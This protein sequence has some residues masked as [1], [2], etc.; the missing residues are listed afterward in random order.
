MLFVPGHN[1]KL[2]ESA[3]RSGA[4]A[5]ILDIEDS[6]RP[7]N[8]KQV[9]REMITSLMTEG[10]FKDHTVFVRINDLESGHLLRDITAL[11]I[12]GV[13]GF[14]Y[15]KARF[16]KD[17]YFIDKLLDTV[18]AGLGVPQGRFKLV[19]L[20]E[21]AAAVLNA[22]EIASA[23]SRVVAIAFGCEDFISD[24]G[25]L[26]DEAGRSLQTP[27]AMIA[28]AAKAAGV[29]A[30]DT[31]HVNVHDLEGLEKNL[32]FVRELGFDGM[33]VLH[34]KELELVHQ[35][36]SPSDDD[37]DRA[38]EMLRLFEE[39]IVQQKGVAILN[40]KFIGPP[41]VLAARKVL[42][43]RELILHRHGPQE[44]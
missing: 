22:Q 13:A 23:S 15:P 40:G 42:A 1:R 8:Q 41:M 6:V 17:I 12:D 33:L 10:L 28:M 14:V 27:R 16:G 11:T 9:A 31:V 30:I 19:P 36:F 32:E 43:R 39:A 25:G 44:K 4:D 18:E 24:L 2:L 38:N 35:Y 34:P 26:H 29:Q 21:M 37:V 7:D 3:V 20:I 5:L